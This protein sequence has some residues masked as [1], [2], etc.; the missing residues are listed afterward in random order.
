MRNLI[1]WCS[2]AKRPPKTN[3]NGKASLTLDPAA[4]AANPPGIGGLPSRIPI[5]LELGRTGLTQYY[6]RVVEEILPELQYERGRRILREMSDNDPVVGALLYAIVLLIRGVSSRIE[7]SERHDPRSEFIEQCRQDMDHTWEDLLAEAAR[8]TLV[9]GWS[10]HEL[11]YKLREDANSMF[12]DGKV[13]WKRMPV[14]SQESLWRWDFNIDTQDLQGMY[15]RP[16]PDFKERY[17]PIE[18]AL[19][20]RTESFRNNPEGRSAL[21]NAYRPWYFNKHIEQIEAIGI[22]RDLAGY[23]IIKIPQTVIDTGGAAYDQWKKI[24]VNLRRDELEGLIIPSTVDPETKLPLYEVTLLHSPGARQFDTTQIINRYDTRIL[25]T[26]LGDFMLLGH[27]T[28]SGSFAMAKQKT[29]MF[30]EALKAWLKSIASTF[31]RY[32]I[33]RLLELNGMETEDSPQL[34]F[35]DV[36]RRDIEAF[37]NA[38]NK[39]VTAGMPLF[40]NPKLENVI[41]EMLDLPPMLPEELDTRES[42]DE[43]DKAM[44]QVEAAARSAATV[45]TSQARVE[46]PQGAIAPK[47]GQPKATESK[48]DAKPS[49]IQKADP[50]LVD[51]LLELV[52]R[53]TKRPDRLR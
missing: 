45:A 30:H 8:G 35:G 27:T 6:G 18:K 37:G 50:N 15:Q 36:E 21:R 13:G 38:I 7:S 51:R 48:P 44:A 42:E 23:P 11:V 34:I 26:V 53:M 25:L 12:P 17:V 52:G 32:A 22:E 19:L 3:G 24:A 28:R 47:P 10:L 39:L 40:P 41:L 33:P 16:P 9:F 43:A 49:G 5:D 46:N 31:N 4:P 14:R 1:F 20:F 2:M 29:D